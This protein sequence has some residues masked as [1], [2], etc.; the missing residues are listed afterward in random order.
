M[1]DRGEEAVLT[2]ALNEEARHFLVERG[3]AGAVGDALHEYAAAM[4]CAAAGSAKRHVREHGESNAGLLRRF[5]GVA[6]AIEGKLPQQLRL[7]W[8]MHY[9]DGRALSEYAAATGLGRAE[10]L[11]DYQALTRALAA[12]ARDACAA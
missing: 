10:A 5:V 11:A 2:Q 8:Q 9:V 4:F 12:A 3:A 6:D 7:L 1:D